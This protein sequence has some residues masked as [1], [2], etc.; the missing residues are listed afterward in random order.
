VYPLSTHVLKKNLFF[1]L[2]KIIRS[3]YSQ[4]EKISNWFALAQI[5]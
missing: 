5:K 1:F 4:T 2:I 3:F